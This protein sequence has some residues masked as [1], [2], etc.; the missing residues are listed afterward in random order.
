VSEAVERST[1]EATHARGDSRAADAPQR[2]RSDADA[3]A[4]LDDARLLLWAIYQG[5][6]LTW[7]ILSKRF[8][9]IRS[10]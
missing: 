9:D 6:R 8:P 7:A 3:V 10:W 2:P 4:R 1:R 5:S